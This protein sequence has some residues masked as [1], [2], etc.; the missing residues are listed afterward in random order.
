[1]RWR[2]GSD[3]RTARMAA[4][5]IGVDSRLEN[6]HK[7]VTEFLFTGEQGGSVMSLFAWFGDRRPKFSA[8]QSPASSL[9]FRPE[10]EALELRDCPSV[11]APINVN[12]TAVSSTQVKVTWNDVS[13]E[14]GYRIY[15]WDG[16]R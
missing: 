2:S 11:A 7:R 5:E 8:R 13:G 1:L 14:L 3:Q 6:G 16:T 15:Q 10:V 4:G 12:P 9:T